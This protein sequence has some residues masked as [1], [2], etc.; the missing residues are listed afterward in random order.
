MEKPFFIMM[1]NQRGDYASPATEDNGDVMLWHT[2]GEAEEAM[3]GHIYAEAFG[4]EVHKLG[5]GD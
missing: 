2:A 1:F 5:D 4:Y 3:R